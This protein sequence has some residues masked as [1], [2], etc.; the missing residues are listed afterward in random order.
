MRGTVAYDIATRQSYYC[1]SSEKREGRQLHLKRSKADQLDQKNTGKNFFEYF[2][3]S[4]R[5]NQKWLCLFRTQNCEFRE[6]FKT[7]SKGWLVKFWGTN[8]TIFMPF[9]QSILT[10]C[11]KWEIVSLLSHSEVFILLFVFIFSVVDL[12]MWLWCLS[13]NQ[14]HE[15]NCNFIL[16]LIRE[17]EWTFQLPSPWSDD[18]V[19]CDCD[20]IGL[21]WFSL[22]SRSRSR[23]MPF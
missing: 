19:Q 2:C 7:F 15:S 21:V 16:S 10:T 3:W 5:I 18:A 13:L 20:W 14:F 17:L 9:L 23:I 4:R 22:P 1:Y 6:V 8:R 11:S 12:T